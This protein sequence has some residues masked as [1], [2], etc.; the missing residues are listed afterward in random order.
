MKNLVKKA[1]GKT[2]GIAKDIK[3]SIEENWGLYLFIISILGFLVWSL[4]M[5][6]N[7]IRNADNATADALKLENSMIEELK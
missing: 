1:I 6:Y 7:I 5:V 3:E 2:K 4:C